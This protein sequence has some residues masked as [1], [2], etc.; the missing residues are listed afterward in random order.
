M[1][2]HGLRGYEVFEWVSDES[3]CLLFPVMVMS[4]N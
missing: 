3:G 4:I 2:A 1:D